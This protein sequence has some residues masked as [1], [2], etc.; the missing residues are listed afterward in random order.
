MVPSIS[1]DMERRRKEGQQ[2]ILFVDV[3][4]V[5]EYPRRVMLDLLP[6]EADI[7]C[8][9]PMFGPIS[10]ANGWTNLRF[11]YEKTRVNME[12]L[13]HPDG[14]EIKGTRPALS[15]VMRMTV[16]SIA[17]TSSRSDAEESDARKKGMDR[18]ERFLSIWEEEGCAMKAMSCTDHDMYAAKSQFITHLMGRVLGQQGLE[19]TPVD[20]KG[21]ESILSLVKSTTS[22]SYDLFYGL[23]HYNS[24]SSDIMI[25]LRKALDEVEKRLRDT[26]LDVYDC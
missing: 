6:P 5:K 8:C 1:L 3:C 19:P 9:H 4:S 13:E 26:E 17:L 21:F 16:R 25:D 18:M 11:I 24:Y 20:T 7:L 10:G 23:Y 12:L 15:R 2:G 14:R 22:D